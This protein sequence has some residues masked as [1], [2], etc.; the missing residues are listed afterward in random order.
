MVSSAIL[1]FVSLFLLRSISISFS[2][3]SSCNVTS[4]FLL[5]HFVHFFGLFCS[6]RFPCKAHINVLCFLICFYGYTSP[7][8]SDIWVWCVYVCVH[9]IFSG[10]KSSSRIYRLCLEHNWCWLLL[11]AVAGNINSSCFALLV[12]STMNLNAYINPS[13][14]AND[15]GDQSRT[16]TIKL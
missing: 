6:S 8:T 3:S 12:C 9:D 7:N 4:I 15:Q 1:I 2:W 10:V 14:A 13:V 5:F 16:V 11:L